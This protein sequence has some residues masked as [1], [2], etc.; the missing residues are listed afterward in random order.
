MW[1][2]VD[3]GAGW[4]SSSP[5]SRPAY[6]IHVLEFFDLCSLQVNQ[7]SGGCS[8][9]NYMIERQWVTD[10]KCLRMVSLDCKLADGRDAEAL[11]KAT[12]EA[13]ETQT[14]KDML[15]TEKMQEYRERLEAGMKGRDDAELA[16]FAG[17]M[18]ALM[19]GTSANERT[20][21]GL[22][23]LCTSHNVTDKSNVVLPTFNSA[24]SLIS[25]NPRKCP[26]G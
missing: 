19:Q 12:L 25:D 8:K 18:N 24:V 16:R 11:L 4:A 2:T 10:T 21:K 20:T 17:G 26:P 15:Y 3:G 14:L 5:H 1:L 7:N 22:E 6:V 13:E 23:E 9:A